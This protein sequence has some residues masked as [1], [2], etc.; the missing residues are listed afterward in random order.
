[1]ISVCGSTLSTP[2]MLSSVSIDTE[3]RSRSSRLMYVRSNP[4]AAASASWLI[5]ARVRASFRLRANTVRRSMPG[6]E[7]GFD[8][9]TT[10]Y[11]HLF[12]QGDQR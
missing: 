6:F 10:E 11:T 1:M 12:V 2:A 7:Q 9:A 8:Y 4:A 3:Y 5:P